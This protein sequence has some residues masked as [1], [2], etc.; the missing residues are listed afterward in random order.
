MRASLILVA[1]VLL[2]IIGLK[3]RARVTPKQLHVQATAARATRRAARKGGKRLVNEDGDEHGDD[4]AE[5][6][7]D[8]HAEADD[9]KIDEMGRERVPTVNGT[10]EIESPQG[11]GRKHLHFCLHT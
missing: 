2:G 1:I 11:S 9:K 3:S 5:D 10:L 6:D 8:D 4:D 7:A